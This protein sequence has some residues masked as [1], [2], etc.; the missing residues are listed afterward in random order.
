MSIGSLPHLNICPSVQPEPQ[1]YPDSGGVH[2]VLLRKPSESIR[3][4]GSASSAG[5]ESISLEALRSESVPSTLKPDRRRRE[6]KYERVTGTVDE[7]DRWPIGRD[8]KHA[9]R[10]ARVR[11]PVSVRRCGPPPDGDRLRADVAGDGLAH[12]R[13]RDDGVALGRALRP[14]RR[15]S[16]SRR[17]TSSRASTVGPQIRLEHSP[18]DDLGRGC[19]MSLHAPGKWPS[20]ELTFGNS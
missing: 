16:Q 7:R 2:S 3:F 13:L 9:G 18:S 15:S 6:S 11:T 1:R 20:R 5:E 4:G 14:R 10:T 8:G 19:S 12:G 17:G